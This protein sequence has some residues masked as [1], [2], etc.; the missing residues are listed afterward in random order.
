M[1]FFFC[2][3]AFLTR[4]SEGLVDLAAIT[5]HLNKKRFVINIETNYADLA[6]SVAILSTGLDNADPP[7]TE[8]SKELHAS[9]NDRVDILVEKIRAMSNQVID[10]GAAHRKRTDAKEVLESLLASLL[11]SVRTDQKPKGMLWGED[12]GTEKQQ[13]M[14]KHFVQKAR[15]TSDID[16]NM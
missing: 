7:P 4:G 13:S 16:G 11:F 14:M 6:A 12:A 9:F 3:R 10:T 1:A 2:D 5:R 15:A 8:A